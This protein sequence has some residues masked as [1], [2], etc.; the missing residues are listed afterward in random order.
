MKK[1]LFN[2]LMVTT[3]VGLCCIGCKKDNDKN[4]GKE[5]NLPA[6]VN[7][8][9]YGG[10]LYDVAAHISN[11]G[12]FY[13][14]GAESISDSVSCAIDINNPNMGVAE[15]IT[16]PLANDEA[17]RSFMFYVGDTYIQQERGTEIWG[18]IGD[19]EYETGGIFSNGTATFSSNGNGKTYIL[20]G[21]LKNGKRICV[22]I[23]VSA[24]SI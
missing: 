4:S 18:A 21:T 7:Q 16:K 9:Y 22:N 11:N 15:D 14:I 24:D 2:L 23:S 3:L 6:G 1:R 20:D 13:M 19:T 5:D 10:N 12:N 8:I 17:H